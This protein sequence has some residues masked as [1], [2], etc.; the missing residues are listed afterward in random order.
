MDEKLTLRD[1]F[2]MAALQGMIAHYGNDGDF[3]EASRLAYEHADNMLEA[4]Q[5]EVRP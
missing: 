3:K 5:K 2:A 4:R 1:Q